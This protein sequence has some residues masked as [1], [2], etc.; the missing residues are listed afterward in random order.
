[1]TNNW[2]EECLAKEIEELASGIE[3]RGI[4]GER[5][6]LR[7]YPEALPQMAL[8]ES[9]EQNPS[10]SLGDSDPQDSL[11]PYCI[12]RTTEVSYEDDEAK[13]KVYLV[14][15]LCDRDEKMA[16]YRTMWNLMNRVTGRFRKN[17]V[18][19][20]FWCDRKMKA[21]SQDEDTWPYFFGGIEMSWHMPDMESEEFEDE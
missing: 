20:A 2:L 15:C 5:K 7:G 4:D 11:I 3:L 13:A 19:D 9:W 1:M 18:L 16:G 17:P 14:F 21:V 12:V 6:A 10:D 8:P